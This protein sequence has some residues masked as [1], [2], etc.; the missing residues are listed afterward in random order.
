[1]DSDSLSIKYDV[2][3]CYETHTALHYATNLKDAL[4]KLKYNAFV[5]ATQNAIPLGVDEASFRFQILS[6]SNYFLLIFV[7]LSFESAEVKR[8]IDHAIKEKKEIILCID[9]AINLDRFKIQFPS[10]STLERIQG[11]NS[12]SEL[13]KLV[14]DHFTSLKL[15]KK[16]QGKILEHSLTKPESR[17]LLVE[18]AWSVKRIS[19]NHTSGFLSFKTKNNS[20]KKIIL[21]GYKIFR[22]NPQGLTD[23]FYNGIL[24]SKQDYIDWISDP[25]FHIILWANDEHIFNWNEVNIVETY[26]INSEGIW[27]TEL[28]IA[29][30]VDGV[31]NELFYSTGQT[32][33]EYK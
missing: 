19:E 3:I 26:G 10:L 4:T 7:N 8:E 27:G 11:F 2:F 24:V 6:E 23:F 31:E 9:S 30:L 17:G 28:Q 1:M 16:I 22:T 29:Y 18:P 5:A 15:Q 12:A 21:Y 13:A 20:G 14:I 33:I 25:H 32:E